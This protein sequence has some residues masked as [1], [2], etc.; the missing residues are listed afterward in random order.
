MIK[1]VHKQKNL[2]YLTSY[3]KYLFTLV[4]LYRGALLLV[5]L[6]CK[7]KKERND[8]TGSVKKSSMIKGKEHLGALRST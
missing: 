2:S 6:L 4:S 3:T 1:R 8:F 7:N 5:A